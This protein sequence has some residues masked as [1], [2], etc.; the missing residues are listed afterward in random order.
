M[1]KKQK[2]LLFSQ[3]QCYTVFACSKTTI[4][5]PPYHPHPLRRAVIQNSAQPFRLAFVRTPN[6]DISP[7]SSNEFSLQ[8]LHV[9]TGPGFLSGIPYGNPTSVKPNSIEQLIPCIIPQRAL[10]ERSEVASR[11]DDAVVEV[12]GL[13]CTATA[14]RAPMGH[15]PWDLLYTSQR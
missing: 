13:L 2:V 11:S 7:L 4:V 9:A 10:V 12:N 8:W 3:S 14:A 5:Q 1:L 15:A 6:L